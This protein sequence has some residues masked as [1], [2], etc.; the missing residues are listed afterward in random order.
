MDIHDEITAHPCTSL[1]VGP[2]LFASLWALSGL[3][4]TNSTLRWIIRL[5]GRIGFAA[6][7]LLGR[8]RPRLVLLLIV[9][10]TTRSRKGSTA[11]LESV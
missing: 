11:C 8:W 3:A 6:S 10:L 2:M 4:H 1:V 9:L 7:T 5:L